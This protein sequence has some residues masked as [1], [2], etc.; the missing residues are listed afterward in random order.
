MDENRD[1]FPDLPTSDKAMANIQLKRGATGK[2]GLSHKKKSLLCKKKW[3]MRQRQNKASEKKA[4]EEKEAD[5]STP[6][7]DSELE[8][9]DPGESYVHVDEVKDLKTNIAD[10]S[11]DEADASS[12]LED[13]DP[14]KSWSV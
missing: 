11:E 13:A 8:D 2:A 14:G 4:G 9:L 10:G 1:A 3:V 6:Y 7:R 12:E 5:A